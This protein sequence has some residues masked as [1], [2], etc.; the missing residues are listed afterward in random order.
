MYSMLPTGAGILTERPPPFW[1]AEQKATLAAAKILAGNLV[2]GASFALE[3][4]REIPIGLVNPSNPK[5]PLGPGWSC[6]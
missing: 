1:V 2:W 3:T 6:L 4:R 5:N